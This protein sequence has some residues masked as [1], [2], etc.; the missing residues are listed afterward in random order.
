MSEETTPK[1][2]ANDEIDLLDLFSRMGHGL[3]NLFIWIYNFIIQIFILFIRFFLF[4]AKKAVWI[5]IFCIIGLIIGFVQFKG[6]KRYYASEMIAFSNSI[7]NKYIVSAINLLNDPLRTGKENYDVIASYLGV[8]INKVELIKSIKSGYGIDNDLD[9]LV[10]YVDY[11]DEFDAR[12]STGVKL[13]GIFYTQLE[14]FDE[15]MMGQIQ[16]GILNYIYKNKY[17][18]DMN[19][20]R[21]QQ[22]HQRIANIDREIDK[23]DSLQH[24]MY[25]ET[26]KIKNSIPTDKLVFMNEIDQKLYHAEILQLKQ[27]K[28]EIERELE[29][30]AEAITILQPFTPI[31]AAANP[32]LGYLIWRGIIFF[33]LGMIVSIIWQYRKSIW[34]VLFNKQESES[35]MKELDDILKIKKKEE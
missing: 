7:E 17:L 5:G 30:R 8:D 29:V 23:L 10:D 32:L 13:K 3:K 9:G 34:G 16:T 11:N 20:T 35:A 28:L 18:A 2:N 6:S 21:I 12:D 15:S 33:F 19:R 25:F 24:I 27:T 31:A 4:L 1:R 22:Y 14:V 26:P